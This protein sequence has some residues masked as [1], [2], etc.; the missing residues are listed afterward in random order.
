VAQILSRRSKREPRAVPS[1]A[2]IPPEA[3]S[4]ITLELPT[5]TREEL[6]A[7]LRVLQGVFIGVLSR[8]MSAREELGKLIRE[9]K[10]A[11]RHFPRLWSVYEMIGE[12]SHELN[13]FARRIAMEAVIRALDLDDDFAKWERVFGVSLE[14]Y[15]NTLLG[16]ALIREESGEHTPV[17]VRI[18]R[19]GE[20]EYVP[21]EEYRK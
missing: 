13:E 2:R 3:I 20:L 1:G 4:R 7:K 5:Y 21:V 6:E 9:I 11:E 14:D 18:N 12:K 10:E 19:R 16:L 15:Y 8:I 17:V